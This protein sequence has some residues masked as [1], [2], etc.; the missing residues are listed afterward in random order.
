MND[1]GNADIPALIERSRAKDSRAANELLQ[2]VRDRMMG[3]IV[4]RAGKIDSS[5]L[6]QQLIIKVHAH[7]ESF[8]GKTEAEFWAWASAIAKNLSADDRRRAAAKKRGGPTVPLPVDSHG[9]VRIAGHASTPS[10]AA[11]RREAAAA[12]AAAQK[13]LS[14]EEQQVIRLRNDEEL[15]WSDIARIMHKTSEDAVRK[16]YRRTIRKLA[17]LRAEVGDAP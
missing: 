6:A 12:I 8:E 9:G 3:L 17:A 15:E 5:D 4:I 10:S 1:G 14:S 11:Q 16:F 7:L 2:R 13:L